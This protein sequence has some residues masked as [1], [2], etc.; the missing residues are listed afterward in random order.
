MC[1]PDRRRQR[2]LSLIE[3]VMFVVIVGLAVAGVLSVFNI[4]TQKS[5]DPMVRKQLLAIAEAML[6]EVQLMPFTYCDPDDANA[7]TAAAALVGA[8]N[9]A[10]TVEAIG[11]GAG[12]TRYNAGNPFD[13]VD[14]YHGFDS[15]SAVPAGIADLSGTVIGGL[16]GY[17]S[18]VVVAAQAL[19]PAGAQVAA[20]D[21]NGRAQ[22]LR[23]DVTVTGPRG[24][25]ITLSGYRTRYAP[26]ALP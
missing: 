4:T 17:R 22:S 13:N 2:G 3:L 20:S 8:A 7:A 11:P 24:D 6:A 9:C 25:S 1:T 12:E 10:T 5:A 19:G 15:D 14:D 26:T 23:I 18:Q 16:P 21:G